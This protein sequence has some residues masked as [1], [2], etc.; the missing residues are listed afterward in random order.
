MQVVIPPYFCASPNITP[1]EESTRTIKVVEAE[2]Y[3]FVYCTTILCAK[4]DK[5][6]KL[7]NEKRVATM[8][9]HS[10]ALQTFSFYVFPKN[11]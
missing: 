2:I 11:I 6:A 7:L 4:G 1:K 5:S 3:V 8:D 9:H 10:P